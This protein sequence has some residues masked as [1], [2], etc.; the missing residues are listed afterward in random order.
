M[1]TS[2][3]SGSVN[4]RGCNEWNSFYEEKAAKESSKK[5]KSSGTSKPM[6][7]NSVEKM[8]T[9]RVPTGFEELDRVLRWWI[10]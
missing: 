4:V 6:L 2:L 8:Q 7:L 1:D 5:G 10:S 9:Q 3:Q